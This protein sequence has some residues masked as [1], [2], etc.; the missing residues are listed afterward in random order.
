MLGGQRHAPA[1]LPS[2]NTRY[3]L[4]RR[5]GGPQVRSV[6][7]RK[8]SP[9]PGFD[10]RTVQPVTSRYADWAIRPT[11]YV[12]VCVCICVYIYIYIKHWLVV[13]HKLNSTCLA[14]KFYQLLQ[15][16]H[17][18]TYILMSLASQGFRSGSWAALHSVPLQVFALQVV[19]YPRW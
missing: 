11:W 2:G 18:I 19:W 13:R 6:W 12:C 5:L 10:P 14:K 15:L 16:N 7:V 17:R 4:Y 8:N 9:P 1:V 3:P